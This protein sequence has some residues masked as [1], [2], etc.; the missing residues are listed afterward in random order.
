MTKVQPIGTSLP[1]PITKERVAELYGVPMKEAASRLGLSV[2]AFRDIIRQFGIERWPYRKLQSIKEVIEEL[3][4]KN[5]QEKIS[6]LNALMDKIARDPNVAIPKDIVQLR[7]H[8]YKKRH[9]Q[10]GGKQ[11]N[12]SPNKRAK[13]KKRV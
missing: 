4:D 12:P 7:Q 6:M 2:N 13:N 8:V 9:L 5:D 3:G 11:A 1:T 10:K